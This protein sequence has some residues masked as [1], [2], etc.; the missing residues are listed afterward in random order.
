[1]SSCLQ[2][3]NDITLM[4]APSLDFTLTTQPRVSNSERVDATRCVPGR[5]L[6]GS[7]GSSIEEDRATTAAA[8]SFS[9]R[10]ATVASVDARSA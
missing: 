4:F 7:T 2:L 8:A 5:G 3:N 1:M 9:R 6:L 10:S